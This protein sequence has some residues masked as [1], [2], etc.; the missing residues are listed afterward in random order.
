MVFFLNI[1]TMSSISVYTTGTT[2]SVRR[3]DDKTPP[4]T[5]LGALI[6]APGSSLSASGSIPNTVAKVV[7]IIERNLT[8]PAIKTALNLETPFSRCCFTKSIKI[9]AFLV[10]SPINI[11]IPI[12]DIIDS[13]DQSHR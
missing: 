4:I 9:I 11:T 3:A 2:T 1:P 7:I 6:S 5:A 13:A 12:I 8:G 10:T